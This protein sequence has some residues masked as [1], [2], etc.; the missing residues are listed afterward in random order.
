MVN[1]T[2]SN[3]QKVTT[4]SN[5]KEVTTVSNSDV[6]LVETS[7]E[8][9]KVTKGNLLKEVNEELNAKS[10][11]NHTHD[12]YVTENELDNKG[13]ATESFVTQKIAEASLSGGDV[14]LSGYATIDF[15]TQEINSIELTPGPKGDKGDTGPQG[16]QGP[17][18]D[19]GEPGTTSWNDLQDKPTIPSI[20]GLATETYVT[21][22]IAEAKLVGGGG[23]IA[24]GAVGYAKLDSNLSEVLQTIA[25]VN[26]SETVN[27]TLE[28]YGDKS[29]TITKNGNIYTYTQIGAN[30]KDFSVI[31]NNNN[32]VKAIRINITDSIYNGHLPFL[33]YASHNDDDT[34]ILLSFTQ[35]G[36]FQRVQSYDV[37]ANTTAQLETQWID[38]SRDIEIRTQ[39]TTL[40]IINLSTN[41]EVYN[42]DLN[43]LYATNTSDIKLGFG[44]GCKNLN[45]EL[46]ENANSTLTT[47]TPCHYNIPKKIKEL[48]DLLKKSESS[49]D[50][51]S[52]NNA[53]KLNG[54]KWNAFGDSI[55]EYF[56]N[57][58]YITQISAR[59]GIVARNY[60]KAGRSIASR[61]EALDS[62][63]LPAY[64]DYI[65]MNDDA[66]IIT[67]FCGTNDYGSQ[68][69]IGTIDSVDNSTFYGALNTLSL[70]LIEKFP[71]KKIAYITPLQRKYDSNGTHL[72]SYVNA[73]KNI[74][75][76]YGIPV[77]DLYSNCGL[78]P[79][80]DVINNTY[81]KDGDGLHPNEAGNNV[82]SP[83][84]QAF[85]E[86]I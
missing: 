26:I 75:T 79:K 40:K 57:D 52:T 27:I 45:F 1:K 17:K 70:G 49:G 6:L 51:S 20:E 35:K 37:G 83:R 78:Y 8:T 33:I 34:G 61:G 56:P 30:Y 77:C 64:S 84:I 23:D 68:V 48:E 85:L 2:M 53:S 14:D 4:V 55:T 86:S 32:Y 54:L 82:I 81:F 22:A 19:K 66:D 15:V 24:D 72:S 29:G 69:S 74:G 39:G 7:T 16:L 28:K 12:E 58:N 47:L 50:V 63:Y 18:G 62:T 36:I 46:L 60:G 44:A 76:K 80:S 71:G 13:L 73:I 67:V 10:D 42:K 25:E 9:L 65:N 3:L 59:T 5:L 38:C 31:K 11:A 43:A 41:S 21:N